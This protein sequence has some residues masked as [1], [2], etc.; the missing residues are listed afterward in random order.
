MREDLEEA[1][2]IR[3]AD[4]DAPPLVSA[5]DHVVDAVLDLDA[6]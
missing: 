6:R 1:L 4:E 5:G 2:T 3:Y